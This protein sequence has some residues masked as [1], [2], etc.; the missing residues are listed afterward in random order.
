MIIIVVL[1]SLTFLLQSRGIGV[2]C[3]SPVAMRLLT[4]DAPPEWHPA[5]QGIKDACRAAA[6]YCRVSVHPLVLGSSIYTSLVLQ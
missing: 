1:N 4:N 6:V 2:I 3:A 5:P